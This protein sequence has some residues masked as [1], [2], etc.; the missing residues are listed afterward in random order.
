MKILLA[1]MLTLAVAAF[2]LFSAPL[3][4]EAQGMSD[5]VTTGGYGYAIH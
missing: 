4:S 5:S 1:A 3:V 2:L